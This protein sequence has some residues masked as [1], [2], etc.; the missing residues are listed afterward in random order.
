MAAAFET[1]DPVAFDRLFFLYVANGLQDQFGG[2]SFF[3][4]NVLFQVDKLGTAAQLDG[5]TRAWQQ[6]T[7]HWP[8]SDAPEVEINGSSANPQGTTDA[9][10]QVD[11]TGVPASY[12]SRRY[13]RQSARL[14]VR[15]TG[16]D[17]NA[18]PNAARHIFSCSDRYVPA[19]TWREDLMKS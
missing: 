11:L 18:A 7:G 13:P 15:K 12:R 8:V 19:G 1:S 4:R 5:W 16:G 9:T 14:P 3:R 2:C 10:T 17:G 6:R